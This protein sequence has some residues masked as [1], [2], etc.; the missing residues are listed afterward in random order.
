LLC[1]SCSSKLCLSELGVNQR[2]KR[3]APGAPG[4]SG[5]SGAPGAPGQPG[6]PGDG[7]NYDHYYKKKLIFI[8]SNLFVTNI[9]L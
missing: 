6:K 7:G 8:Q 9:R 1:I 2:F 5:S 4:S 3:G